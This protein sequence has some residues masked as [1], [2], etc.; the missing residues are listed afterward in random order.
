MNNDYYASTISKEKIPFIQK[1][2]IRIEEM[3]VY[4]ID[5]FLDPRFKHGCLLNIAISRL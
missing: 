2:I 1:R 5:T 4:A 3:K